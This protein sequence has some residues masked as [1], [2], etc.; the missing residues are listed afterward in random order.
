MSAASLPGACALAAAA[1]ANDDVPAPP[2][3][4][5]ADKNVRLKDDKELYPSFVSFVTA[6]QD[7]GVEKKS[8]KKVA[9]GE[10]KHPKIQ[11]MC[12]EL[13]RKILSRHRHRIPTL[14]SNEN[15]GAKKLLHA[16]ILKRKKRTVAEVDEMY[17]SFADKSD[18]TVYT[19]ANSTTTYGLDIVLEAF[20]NNESQAVTKTQLNRTPDDA[21]RLV[22][23]L[24]DPENRGTVQ[25]ILTGKK[26]RKKL[27]QSHCTTLA[28]FEEKCSDF[29]NPK[30]IARNPKL[31]ANLHDSDSFDPNNVSV[32]QHVLS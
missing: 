2:T 25:G 26:D 13:Y 16:I 11:K 14:D 30:Y 3:A 6:L 4:A 21:M 29:N 19:I 9:S 17:R 8:K 32:S 31:L 15:R 12:L 22:W 20:E 24:L 27:D 10:L 7:P 5:L 18:H 23:I 28:F 1:S